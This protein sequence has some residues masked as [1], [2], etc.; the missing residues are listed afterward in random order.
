MRI[1][2]KSVAA[3]VATLAVAGV[4][5]VAGATTAFA[6]YPVQ[7]AQEHVAGAVEFYDGAGNRVYSGDGTVT[8]DPKYFL[9]TGTLTAPSDIKKA[10]LFGATPQP[11]QAPGLWPALQLGSNKDYPLVGAPASVSGTPTNSPATF[12]NTAD[13]PFKNLVYQYTA[14]GNP[15]DPDWTNLYEIRI[16]DFESTEYSSTY[17][18]IDPVTYAWKQVSPAPPADTRAATTTTLSVDPASG[19]TAPADLTLKTTVS[20]ATAGSVEF[21]NGSTS[22]GA[23]V[24]VSGGSASK[25]LTAV[26]EG[27]YSYT[28]KFTSTDPA[29]QSSTSNTVAYTVSA[30]PKQTPTVALTSSSAAPAVGEPVTFTATVSAPNAPGKI[31]FFDGATSIGGP[32]ATDAAGVA[33]MTTSTLAEGA[34]TITAK[35]VPTDATKYN[36]ATSNA[37]TVTVLGGACTQPGSVCSDPQ[38]FIVEVPVGSIVISTPFGPTNPFNLGV[39]KLN[40][41]ATELSTGPKSFK[42]Q[43]PAGKGV[44]ITDQRSGDNP[45]TASLSS[46]NFTSGANTITANNLGFT[47]VVPEYIPG[48]ALQAPDVTTYENKAY[49]VATP[50]EDGLAASQKFAYANPGAGSVYVNGNFTLNAPTSTKAGIYTGIVTFTIA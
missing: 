5:S 20:P 19:A 33:T 41:Q 29:V 39:M 24:A 7:D 50:A 45:W 4:M 15:A 42:A 36:P 38:N 26:P 18:T 10:G 32:T 27:N 11:G 16:R 3:G 31:E 48:N 12:R 22:L 1:S 43:D 40:E 17:I 14:P 49:S 21:F 44:T 34:H 23:P 6:A 35:F 8:E 9:S 46:S 2:L 13:Q 30:T 25:T 37:V 47:E 28:A